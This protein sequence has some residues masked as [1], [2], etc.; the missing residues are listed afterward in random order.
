MI[1]LTETNPVLQDG[2]PESQ[3]MNEEQLTTKLRQHVKEDVQAYLHHVDLAQLASADWMEERARD[4]VQALS[5]EIY[6]AWTSALEAAAKELGG[7]C[8]G[9]GRP[10][11]CKRRPKEQMEI[12]LLGIEVK[13]PKLYLE[14]GHCQAPG[15][16]VTKVLT[17]LCSGDASMELKLMVAYSA[18]EHSYGKA[19]Q[20]HKAHYGQEV[21]RTAARRMALEVEGLAMEF[22]EQERAKAVERVAGEAKTVGVEQLMMQGDGGS[23]RTGS[24]VP[25]EK[26]DEGY[27]KKTPK[28]NKPRRKRPT[29]KREVITLDVREP[30][31]SIPK[32]LDVVVPCEAPQGQRAERMLA[33]AARCGLGD[34][35][36][37]LGLGDL[38]SRLPQ[39]FD[40]AF[41]GFESIYSGDWKHICDYVEKVA[42]V[43]DGPEIEQWGEKM[44]DAIW[45]CDKAQCD[46]L[47][48]KAEKAKVKAEKAKVNERVK[49]MERC[50]VH[51]LSTYLSNNWKRLNAAQFK[52]MGVDYVSARAE[53]QVRERTKKRFSV[54]GA[55]RQENLEGKATLRAIIDEGSWARFKRW[56]RDR[57]RNTFASLLLE[58][59]TQAI[60]EGRL[61]AKEETMCDTQKN[62][63]PLVKAA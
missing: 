18:A 28:T 10:R 40:D 45:R 33:L 1:P 13:V 2:H 32:G 27:G 49:D 29:Q 44:R 14:C 21:E 43:L 48:R 23:V 61:A 58:R 52:A 26:G 30:G 51:A 42:A 9:C 35:T 16:S 55:W 60:G 25:C 34:N 41:V 7:L 31:Q 3:K 5:E 62:S 38:G 39:S 36:Q 24:L 53:A 47:L 22:A 8:P 57:S 46:K 19:S 11:K 54:P 6:E 50:P 20:D 59:I 56:C 17:G 37:M 4:I 12:R 63:L 15:L